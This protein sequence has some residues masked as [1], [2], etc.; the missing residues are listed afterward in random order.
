MANVN[1]TRVVTG[2]PLYGPGHVGQVISDFAE[3][4]AQTGDLDA[5][6]T[7]TMLRLP[8]DC[9]L[10]GMELWTDALDSGSGIVLDV[11]DSD[12]DDRFIA[13]STV[14]Q[15]GG[16]ERMNAI[17]GFGHKV[18]ADTDIVI[19]VDTGPG[20]AQ[21]GTIKLGITYVYEG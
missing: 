3:Y 13:A 21:A 9:R 12:D 19:L 1:S 8:A 15:A 16:V 17:G 4:E 5:S 7:F 14:G 18:T 10:L 20:G 11:G 6:D 2:A